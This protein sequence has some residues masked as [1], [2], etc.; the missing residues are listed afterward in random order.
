V[1]PGPARHIL[2]VDDDAMVRAVLVGQLEDLGYVV[3]QAGDGLAAL[4][5]LDAGAETDL[6]VTDFAMPGMNGGVLIGEARR[7]RP[8][9]PTLLLTGYADLGLQSSVDREPGI[10]TVLLRKPVSGAE[11]AEQVAALLDSREAALV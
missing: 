6:L 9:L 2:V 7:R 1:V 5:Q 10:G 3:T 4:A 8:A 11:L